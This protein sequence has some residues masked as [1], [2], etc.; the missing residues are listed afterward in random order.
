MVVQAHLTDPTPGRW[1]CVVTRSDGSRVSGFVSGVTRRVIRV[2][3]LESDR[4]TTVPW[5]VVDRV[6]I[7]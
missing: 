5:S 3:D 2:E 1:G 4:V 6:D 7:P